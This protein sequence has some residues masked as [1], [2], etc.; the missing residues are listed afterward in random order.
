M[1]T[2][3]RLAATSLDAQE[4]LPDQA[5]DEHE[6]PRLVERAG[7][8]GGA[9]RLRGLEGCGHGGACPRR[10]ADLL[11]L[12]AQP[13]GLRVDIEVGD[14][15]LAAHDKRVRVVRLT[16]EGVRMRKKLVACLKENPTIGSLSSEQQEQLLDILREVA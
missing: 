2:V 6:P 10:E 15:G 5:A 7:K 12:E 14:H 1:T 13:H 4:A 16:G 8:R 3:Y 11:A 9:E